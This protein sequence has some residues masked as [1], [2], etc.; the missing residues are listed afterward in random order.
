MKKVIKCLIWIILIFIILLVINYAR[1]N[2][3][4]FINKNN[5]KKVFNIQGNID[6]Y[7]PQGLTYS[8]KYNVIIQ[9][10]YNK[11]NKASMIFITDFNTKKLVKK[12]KL[13][14]LNNKDNTNHVGGI[15]TDNIKLWITSDYEVNEYNLE[16]IMNTKNNYVK[17]IK[18][19]KLPNRGDFCTYKDDTLW[20]GSFHIKIF[21]PEDPI[22][23]GFKVKENINYNK[24]DYKYDIPWLVQGMAITDDNKFVYSQSYTPFHLST[25]SI[26]DK[27]K[28]IKEIRIPPMSEG[29]FYKDNEIYIAFES[30]ATRYFYANPKIDKILKIK[31]DN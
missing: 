18:D 20:I 13:K 21:Y 4:Y 6:N 1:I 25:I 28:L 10:S 19:K 9:T 26:Y 2:I 29:I 31:V 23:H 24:P 14:K 12:L 16:E 5:Y 3:F 8:S 11:Y 30:S 7:A 15:A 27:D 22:L 17:S